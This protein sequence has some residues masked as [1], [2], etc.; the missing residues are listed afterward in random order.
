MTRP[1]KLM[2]EWKTPAGISAIIALTAT[3]GAISLM[4]FRTEQVPAL[5]ADLQ[6]VQQ[7]VSNVEAQG[8]NTEEKVDTLR[9][10]VSELR[11]Q[12]TTVLTTI[13]RIEGRMEGRTANGGGK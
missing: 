4:Y 7:T 10:E 8:K 12:T 5:A 13:G 1:K 6:K 3:I 2:F 9:T 11:Q